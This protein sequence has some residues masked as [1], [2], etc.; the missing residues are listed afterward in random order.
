MEGVAEFLSGFRRAIKGYDRCL[1]DI[2]GRY[3]L[4]QTEVTVISFLHNNPGRDTARDIVELRMLQKGNVSAAVDSLIA[5]GLLTRT[6]DRDDRR[7]Q[8]LRLLESAAPIVAEIEGV[9]ER[10]YRRLFDGFTEEELR[11]YAAMSRRLQE[12]LSRNGAV[13]KVAPDG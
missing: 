13:D 10:F 2:R 3:G 12:N 5:K 1:E 4:S 9:K 8:R 7:R 6:Q 11:Q